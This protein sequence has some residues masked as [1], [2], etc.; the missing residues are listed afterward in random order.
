M[1]YYRTLL[2]SLILALT[3]GT[4]CALAAVAADEP[5]SFGLAAATEEVPAS[6]G[7]APTAPANPERSDAP[8]PPPERREMIFFSAKWCGIPCS[9]VYAALDL[10]K[11]KGWIVT[12]DTGV[13]HHVRTVDYDTHPHMAARLKIELVPTC[14]MLVDG[15]EV[16]RH[17][18]GVKGPEVL[19]TLWKTPAKK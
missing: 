13:P 7:L 15:I 10:L 14:V 1:N 19:T 6:F 2:T 12:D 11:R 16:A 3:L 8:A 17:I 9:T 4:L 18:G 5:I